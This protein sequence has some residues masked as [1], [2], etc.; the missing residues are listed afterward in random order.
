MATQMT[1]SRH[2]FTLIELLV[3][4]AIIAIL[5]AILFPVF[6]QSKAAAKKTSCLSNTKQLGLGW[7]MYSGDNDDVMPLAETFVWTPPGG[8]N[9]WNTWYGQVNYPSV[10]RAS[11]DYTQG[12]LYPYTKNAGIL[13]CPANNF[14]AFVDETSYGLNVDIFWDCDVV[15]G[16]QNYG[17][18]TCNTGEVFGP[19]FSQIQATAETILLGDA[20]Q[21]QETGP[22]QSTYLDLAPYDSHGFAYGV[23][24]GFANL[25]W[26]DGHAASKKPSPI[27][28]QD[29]QTLNSVEAASNAGAIWKT[30]PALPISS[31]YGTPALAPAA[32]YYLMNKQ[33]N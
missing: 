32:Y 3:V 22:S 13:K 19:S 20:V 9:T 8:G 5:A 29:S 25:L 26:C 24:T 4:I 2:A 33:G 21:I 28:I 16:A 6:A 18:G 1:R 7:I 11:V 23:H 15:V 10:G 31:T 30:A 27:D 17:P 12:E 14:Q